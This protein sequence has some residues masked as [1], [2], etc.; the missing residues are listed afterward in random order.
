MSDTSIAV[1][2][3]FDDFEVPESNVR[4]RVAAPNPF[5]DVIREIAGKTVFGK[6]VAKS[7][8][9]DV[10][11]PDASI[12]DPEARKAALDENREKVVSRARR[13][14]TN[15]GNI[16]SPAVTVKVRDVDVK[17]ESGKGKGTVDPTK[18]RVGF[19]TVTKQNRPRKPKV[20]E[21]EVIA[22]EL[23]TEFPTDK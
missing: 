8:V 19:W 15:A 10:P 14:L 21:T 4:G 7:R 20:T 12:T 9:L 2:D 3:D 22:Q 11:Q 5:I 1:A 13:H 6:P 17:I 16:V 23:N 18:V